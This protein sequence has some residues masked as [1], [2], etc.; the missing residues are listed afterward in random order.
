M[1]ADAKVAATLRDPNDR[2]GW[3]SLLREENAR[4]TRFLAIL[5]RAYR[6]S[7]NDLADIKQTALVRIVLESRRIDQPRTYWHYWARIL[8]N[9]VL[10]FVRAQSRS[11]GENLGRMANEAA[12]GNPATGLA[13][14]EVARYLAGRSR[15]MQ[16]VGRGLALGESATE[17]AARTGTTLATVYVLRTRIRRD[18]AS[19]GAGA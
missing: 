16:E 4:I 3:E 7:D 10:D 19:L 1:I 8:R 2:S 12:P 11:Y 9:C 13:V 5:G 18:L 17:T 15:L 14:R 6:I